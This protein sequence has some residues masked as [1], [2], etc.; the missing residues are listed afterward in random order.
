MQFKGIL[1]KFAIQ[2]GNYLNSK[3]TYNRD[4]M[5]VPIKILINR[6]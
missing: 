4:S 2:V 5:L 1:P 6:I 3:I